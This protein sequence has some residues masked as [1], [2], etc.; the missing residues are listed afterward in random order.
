MINKII[1]LI[2]FFLYFSIVF[3]QCLIIIFRTYRNLC[4]LRCDGA[5]GAY[6]GSCRPRGGCNCNRFHIDPV[7]DVNGR[8]YRNACYARCVHAIID[9]TG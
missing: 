5:T 9:P 3:L 4:E 2:P 8:T 7:C 6:R 1:S